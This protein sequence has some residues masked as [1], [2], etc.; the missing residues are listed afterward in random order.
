M[1]GGGGGG[2]CVYGDCALC[3]AILT[4]RERIRWCAFVTRVCVDLRP[5]M[6]VFAY[7]AS[8]SACTHARTPI[9]VCTYVPTCICIC[10]RSVPVSVCTRCFFFHGLLC[11]LV[12]ERPGVVARRYVPPVLH[13]RPTNTSNAFLSE[14]RRYLPSKQRKSPLRAL[15]L[16]ALGRKGGETRIGERGG[17]RGG[18][19]A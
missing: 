14:G 10:A 8:V 16:G 4:G 7:H 15:K 13:V 17:R 5:C 9:P 2:V 1:G 18:R 12:C 3:C 11:S 6:R 19:G